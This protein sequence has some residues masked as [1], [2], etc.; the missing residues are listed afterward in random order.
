MKKQL[1]LG[2]VLLL[3]AMSFV[4]PSQSASGEVIRT[5]YEATATNLCPGYPGCTSGEWSFPGGNFHVRDMVT[6]YSSTSADGRVSGINTTVMSANWDASFVGV[7][8]GTYRLESDVFDGYWKGTYTV[9]MDEW[10]YICKIRGKGYGAFE[11]LQLK[12]IE[13]NGSV[14]GVISELPS[15]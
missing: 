10:G 3:V 7:G 1:I 8:W 5:T 14:V 4:V 9:Q 12:A 6:I 2:M 15:H 11:G 13:I